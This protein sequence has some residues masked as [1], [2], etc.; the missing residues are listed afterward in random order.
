[1]SHLIGLNE[2]KKIETIEGLSK[3]LGDV[4]VVYVKSL[5]FHWNIKGENFAVLH[6]FLEEQYTYLATISDQVA[7]RMRTLDAVAPGSMREFLDLATL[8]ES[9]GKNLSA[10]EMMHELSS[11]YAYLI[12]QMRE[13][14]S[15]VPENDS[16]THSLYD[17]LIANFEK[18]LWMINAHVS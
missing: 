11:D 5:K 4:F 12:E 14:N 3:I 17:D 1:M 13:N 2:Q 10:T 15:A 6:A 16:G 8:K 9:H 18:T 7:E